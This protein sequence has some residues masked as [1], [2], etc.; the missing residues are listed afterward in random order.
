MHPD[1]SVCRSA[2]C[3]ILFLNASRILEGQYPGACD[4]Q[5]VSLFISP[6]SAFP[7]R[8]AEQF[9]PPKVMPTLS[10]QF[11][12]FSD[13]ANL[14][15][16]FARG[17]VQ[18]QSNSSSQTN[19]FDLPVKVVNRWVPAEPLACRASVLPFLRKLRKF[20]DGACSGCPVVEALAGY[21]G[22]AGGRSLGVHRLP[23][24]PVS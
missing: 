14:Q 2:C 23:G 18:K 15:N 5:N 13:V 19:R 9:W 3:V 10:F 12:F 22:G 21:R 20:L 7:A 6:L 17:A 4:F 11:C 8:S 16:L 1:A 24:R